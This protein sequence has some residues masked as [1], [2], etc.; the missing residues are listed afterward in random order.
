V[1][2]FVTLF[3]KTAP[4]LLLMFCSS[5][6]TQREAFRHICLNENIAGKKTSGR[7]LQASINIWICIIILDANVAPM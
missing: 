5:A 6:T 2:V 4:A 1:I 7:V 3:E